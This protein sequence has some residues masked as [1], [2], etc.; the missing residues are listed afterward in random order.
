MALTCRRSFAS[1]SPESRGFWGPPTLA[2]AGVGLLFLPPY[3]PDLNPIEMAWSKLKTYVR[4][5]AP[6]SLRE[7]HDAIAAGW[8]TLAAK[9]ARGWF[10]HCGL[11]S[12]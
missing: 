9:D 6:Q 4:S 7:L 8:H 1:S 5:I 12:E 11:I 10:Q 2:E 3:S